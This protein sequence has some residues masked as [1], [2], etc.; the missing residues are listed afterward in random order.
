[1]TS[2]ENLTAFVVGQKWTFAKTYATTWPHESIVRAKVDEDLFVGLV[3]QH[4]RGNG[5]E[6][7]FYDK[8][9]KYFEE[10][11]LLYWTMGSPME[12]TTIVNRCKTKQ[13]YD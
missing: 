1:M 4:I 3:Q 13:S 11:G 9:I 6:A 2:R 5:F 12:K 8:L 7:D 10:D